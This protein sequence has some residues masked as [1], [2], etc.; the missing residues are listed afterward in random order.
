MGGWHSEDHAVGE[1]DVH[2]W[3]IEGYNKITNICDK[4]TEEAIV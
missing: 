1:S 3:L 4:F 2:K